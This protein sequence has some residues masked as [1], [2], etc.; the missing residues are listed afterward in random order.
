MTKID[1]APQSIDWDLDIVGFVKD[2]IVHQHKDWLIKRTDAGSSNQIKFN[3]LMVTH[4]TFSPR[5]YGWKL[6]IA[7]DLFN[8]KDIL[9]SVVPVLLEFKLSF[10]VAETVNFLAHLNDDTRNSKQ[11]GKFITV[12]PSNDD[13]AVAFAKKVHGCTK[14][15]ISPRIVTDRRFAVD[16]IVYYRYGAFVTNYV[17]SLWGS[18]LPVIYRNG[19]RLFDLRELSSELNSELKDPFNPE[20]MMTSYSDAEEI[21]LNGYLLKAGCL[22][23]SADKETYLCLDMKVNRRCI[24][25]MARSKSTSDCAG[26]NAVTRLRYEMLALKK[27]E[28][29]NIAPEVYDSFT[30]YQGHFCCVMADIPGITLYEVLRKN[31]SQQTPMELSTL[32]SIAQALAIMLVKLHSHSLIHADLKLSNILLLEDQSL[33]LIDFDS[34]CDIAENRIIAT[35]GSTGF[36]TKNRRWGKTPTTDDDIYGYGAILYYLFGFV[37]PEVCPLE[38]QQSDIA[39]QWLNSIIPDTINSLIEDCLSGV[40]KT[41]LEIQKR[42]QISLPTSLP[43]EKSLPTIVNYATKL[44]FLYK[45]FIQQVYQESN[46]R[47]VVS[48]SIGGDVAIN[49]LRGASGSLLSFTLYSYVS[50]S[51]AVGTVLRSVSGDLL[52]QNHTY[53]LIPGLYVGESG[54]ALS[55]LY[56]GIFLGDNTLRQEAM[57]WLDNTNQYAYQAVDL[58]NGLA[59]RCRVN[60]IFWMLTQE[61]RFKQAA[62]AMVRHLCNEKITTNKGIGWYNPASRATEDCFSLDKKEIQLGYA[63]GIA[64]IGD[65]LLDYY[66][67]EP[68]QDL[69]SVLIEILMTLRTA[70][71]TCRQGQGVTWPYY[72]GGKS[73]PPFWCHGGAGIGIFIARSLQHGFEIF[74]KSI[75]DKIIDPIINATRGSAPI[76]CH[77]SVG[78]LEFMLDLKQ[79]H[80]FKAQL[81][82]IESFEKI[83]S[84]W[85]RNYVNNNFKTQNSQ[86]D[87][88]GY[89]TGIP[90]ILCVYSRLSKPQIPNPLHLAFAQYVRD[91]VL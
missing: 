91:C 66:T 83:V 3:W 86:Y 85:L 47:Y 6:H 64:G 7:A 55:L 88:F 49:D 15:F 27:C 77:G 89:L 10:K 80:P 50:G 70:V 62:E 61:L 34:A 21:L 79:Y 1:Q 43:I 59:G 69:K 40:I 11:V 81:E 29:L 52:K 48:Q 23:R 90:G 78:S 87:F 33:R 54:K 4:K 60:L 16:S 75:L 42:W 46:Q 24:V 72:V 9:I 36:A 63:H 41:A 44:D 58:F 17:Q 25:K 68:N 13:I 19:K 37:N 39:L 74:D 57:R 45:A 82:C 35:A 18:L 67:L 32:C 84:V 71:A 28:G 76:L 20:P 5:D 56:A 51:D 53:N 22:S 31:I 14:H 2:L 8:A 73:V 65:V 26:N 30:N 38:I 12:Y